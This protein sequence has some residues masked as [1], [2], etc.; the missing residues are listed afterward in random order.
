M[1]IHT[2]TLRSKE[3]TLVFHVMLVC[4][5]ERGRRKPSQANASVLAR[6]Y[7]THV[8]FVHAARKS[9]V[10]TLYSLASPLYQHRARVTQY[11]MVG[12]GLDTSEERVLDLVS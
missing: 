6:S 3:Q 2:R 12:L 11:R 4:M 9:R 7:L 5:D 10:L 8:I 1:L